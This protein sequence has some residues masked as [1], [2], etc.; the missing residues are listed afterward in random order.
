MCRN[1][2]CIAKSHFVY[3]EVD[4]RKN[5]LL[6]R[7][8]FV[9]QQKLRIRKKFSAIRSIAVIYNVYQLLSY[10]SLIAHKFTIKTIKI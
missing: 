3:Q 6:A 1:L 9:Y 2:V 5:K 8:V 10:V 4:I 7:S